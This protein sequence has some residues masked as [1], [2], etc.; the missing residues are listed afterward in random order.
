VGLGINGS[1]QPIPV[2]WEDD[3]GDRQA[4]GPEEITCS[5]IHGQTVIEAALDVKRSNGLVPT[6]VEHGDAIF[7][8]GLRL[9]G[10]T[11]RLE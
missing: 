11:E 6:D 2:N 3:L 8:R 4:D 9:R 1:A 10:R 5:L 7:S